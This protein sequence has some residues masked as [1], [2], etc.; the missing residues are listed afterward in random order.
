MKSSEYVVSDGWVYGFN[1]PAPAP[2]PTKVSAA[3]R[4]RVKSLTKSFCGVEVLNGL[5]FEAHAGRI[6][7]IVGENGSGKSTAMNVLTG[8]LPKD[9]GSVELDGSP[10]SPASRRASDA[11][12]I[13]FIQQELNI[14][15]NLSV[16]ENL[17]LLHAP[18]SVEALPL[19]SRRKRWAVAQDLLQ[20]LKLPVSPDTPAGL[21]S[22]GERQLL[23]IARGLAREARVFIL[24]EPTT[25]LT[26]HETARLFEILG[27][28][29]K[30]GAAIL[31]I[32]HNLDHVLTLSDDILVLHDGRVALASPR[33][34]LTAPDLI[35]AMVGRPIE[36]LFPARSCVF[37]TEVRLE[38]AG[39][40]SS[41]GLK[42]VFLSVRAGEI[43]GLAGLMGSGRTELARCLF[44]L[45]PYSEGCIRVEGRRLTPQDVQAS[46]EAGLAFLTEDRRQ[47]GLMLEASV[48]DN[49]ALAALPLYAPRL[50]GGIL[51]KKLARTMRELAARLH[52]KS[53][54][55]EST[56]VRTLS[57]GN[58]Q[59]VVLG[60]WLLRDPKVLI[61]DEPTRGVDIAAKEEIYR[62]LSELADA[63]MAIL[64]I[65]S[66]LEEL[67]GLSDRILVIHA[68][69][70]VARFARREFDR[71][72]ILR[73]TFGHIQ[74]A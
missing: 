60:R 36:T 22:V 49:L 38:A 7:G 74:A 24:D 39:L 19:I 27:R 52:L 35:V 62:L 25:S 31:Y 5:S 69:A 71:E 16:A 23:E 18:R 57:G 65:S 10:F 13:A 66:E 42:D 14:F 45:D 37:G 56:L 28:L 17:F 55:L 33:G 29:R 72:A 54:A 21:L 53:D 68:G 51:K 70:V 34:Q 20:N 61:L 46:V 58:Q 64:L 73:A 50:G 6:L 48:F 30:R 67:I 3:P 40:S 12:G 26:D 59:K 11:A 47:E 63:G 4:L 9:R 15:P 2:A 32:S 1:S 8:V 44:G 43:V 41:G